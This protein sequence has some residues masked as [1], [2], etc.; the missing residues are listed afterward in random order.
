MVVSVVRTVILSIMGTACFSSPPWMLLSLVRWL[1]GCS[2][3][4]CMSDSVVF[5]MRTSLTR[6]KE[7]L[8]TMSALVEIRFRSAR[9]RMIK[10]RVYSTSVGS[11]RGRRL[12]M[13]FSNFLSPA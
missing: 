7:L 11:R 6:V 3:H 8:L 2:R 12:W 5:T 10:M 4:L 9:V 1:S 13:W